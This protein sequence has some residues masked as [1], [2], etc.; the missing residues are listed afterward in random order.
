MKR[1]KLGCLLLLLLLVTGLLSGWIMERLT[2][3]VSRTM[4]AASEAALREDWAE[5]LAL[6]EFA[7]TRWEKHWNLCAVFADHT[8]MENINGLFAQ[9]EIYAQSRDAQNFAAVC[10]QLREDIQAI[11]DAHSFTWWNLL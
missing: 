6:A 11:G 5:A 8:P 3:P 9:L 4:E 10:A 1:S 7:R 2:E